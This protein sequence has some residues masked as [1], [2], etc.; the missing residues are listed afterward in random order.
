[1]KRTTFLQ[2]LAASLMGQNRAR[3]RI[4]VLILT[5]REDHHRRGATALMR[6]Y[7]DSAGVF[8]TRIAEEFR[9]AGPEGLRPCD[10]VVPVYS[11]RAAEDRL[12]AG[13]REALLAFVQSGKGL[14][15]YHHSA[16]AFKT[17]PEFATLSGGSF[18][19]R[20]QHS[21]LHDFEVAFT[22]RDQPVTRG[23]RKSSGPQEDELYA[24]MQMQ[25]HGTYHVLAT[26]WDDHALYEGTSKAPLVGP[27]TNEPVVWRRSV[28]GG[29]VF[30]IMLGHSVQAIQ[31]EGWGTLFTRGVEWA[32]TGEVTQPVPPSMSEPEANR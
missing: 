20:A 31:S 27:G 11:H 17:L 19:G 12:S 26:A 2:L 32:G 1:M 14:V 10:A 7:V 30:A 15:V 25:P 9:D 4:Q 23:L 21:P 8:E 18:Y 24:N 13:T 5:G 22:D 28:G 29:R 16:A 6:D 3:G